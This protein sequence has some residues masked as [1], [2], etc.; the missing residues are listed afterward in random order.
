MNMEKTLVQNLT[1]LNYLVKTN[2][3]DAITELLNENQTSEDELWL[4]VLTIIHEVCSVCR[5][6]REE[7]EWYRDA[8]YWR[9]LAWWQPAT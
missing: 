4:E 2:Q 9:S 7:A 6:M 5:N 3:Y 1:D 8:A